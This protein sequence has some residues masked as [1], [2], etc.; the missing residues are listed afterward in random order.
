MKSFFMTGIVGLMF[1]S[2]MQQS[3]EKEGNTQTFNAS[4]GEIKLIVLAPG[5]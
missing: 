1:L 5:H 4:A 3:K 2:C